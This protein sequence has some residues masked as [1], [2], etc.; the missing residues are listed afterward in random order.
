MYFD[1]KIGLG[2]FVSLMPKFSAYTLNIKAG[3]SFDVVPFP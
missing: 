2:Y 3:P 1:F